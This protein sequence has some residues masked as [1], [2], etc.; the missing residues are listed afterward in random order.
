MYIENLMLF[1]DLQWQYGAYK[2]D[3]HKYEL[4]KPSLKFFTHLQISTF[5]KIYIKIKLSMS[6]NW[7]TNIL[8]SGHF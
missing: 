4:C 2:Y 1:P 6:L 5:Y 3:V 7:R 8:F